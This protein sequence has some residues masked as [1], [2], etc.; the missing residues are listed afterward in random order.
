MKKIFFKKE[1][2]IKWL[3]ENYKNLGTRKCS[4]ILGVTYSAVRNQA[5]KS[6]LKIT[7]ETKNNL[8]NRTAE[9]S[10]LHFLKQRE[11]Y[12]DL[13][14]LIKI[15]SPEKAYGLGF[16]W[17]DGHL[18]K[19]RKVYYASFGI[20][21]EDFDNIIGIFECFGKWKIYYTNREKWHKYNSPNE[22]KWKEIGEARLNDPIFGYF[23]KNNSF[24]EKSIVAPSLIL[25]II[26]EELHYMWWRGYVDADGCFY[27]N[28]KISHCSFSMA[29]TYN[30]DWTLFEK[31]M[32]TLNIKYSLSRR[33]TKSGKFSSVSIS[34]RDGI[35]SF[36]EFIYKNNT[37]IGLNRKYQKFL[38]IKN[39]TKE[40]LDITKTPKYK[41]LE[42]FRL[43]KTAKEI[44]LAYGFSYCRVAHYISEDKKKIIPFQKNQI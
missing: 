22:T 18:R 16:L 29:G 41:C 37:D 30:Q 31:L 5:Y 34:Y 13:S 33:I 25:N 26:P 9:I 19:D 12:N 15:D 39:K 27:H 44:S 8:I 21:K 7:K 32:N 4:E 20:K 28:S 11:K 17:G 40:S 1:C 35:Y 2:D 14:K 24:C 42:L 36:G 38:N 6:G 43:G 3:E 23:L 10:K